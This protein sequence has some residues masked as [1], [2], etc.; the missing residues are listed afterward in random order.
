MKIAL[1]MRQGISAF[2]TGLKSKN[3]GVTMKSDLL[4]EAAQKLREAAD[5]LEAE[6]HKARA[7]EQACTVTSLIKLFL[8]HRAR[9]EAKH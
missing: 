1:L 9:H 2:W 3:G 8:E 5:R 7:E 6:A 4:L